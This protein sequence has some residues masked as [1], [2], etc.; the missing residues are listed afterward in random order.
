MRNIAMTVSYDGTH[1]SGFQIQPGVDTVQQMLMNAVQKV[2]GES[3]H[4]I[5]SGRTDAGVHAI[6]QVINF[7]TESNIP[8]ERWP[9]AMNTVLPRDIAVIAAVEAPFNFNARKH[10][11]RKTYHY[12]IERDRKRSVF[13]EGLAHHHP[14]HLNVNEMQEAA[15]MLLGEHDFSSFCSL[16]STKS[17]HVRT[18]Y[19]VD[20]V[21]EPHP[22]HG[23]GLLPQLVVKVSGNGFLYNMVRIIVGTL[24]MVGRG[25]KKAE[26][27]QAILQAK[28][29]HLAGPTAPPEG[30]FLWQVEYDNLQFPT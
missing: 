16:K 2:T 14:G 1:Y 5:A 15:Q 30:L 28:N 9:I 24:L 4:I 26:E 19:S 22:L 13:T 6:G 7:Y 23:P 3:C 11:V 8:A 20:C 21:L 25:R 29:R 17:S 18:L 12:Y 10:A 27:V